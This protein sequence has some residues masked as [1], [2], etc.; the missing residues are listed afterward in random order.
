MGSEGRVSLQTQL[1]SVSVVLVS[2]NSFAEEDRMKWGPEKAETGMQDLR[3][4][5]RLCCWTALAFGSHVNYQLLALPCSPRVSYLR[6]TLN[7]FLPCFALP[8]AALTPSQ[9][10][11]A[12]CLCTELGSESPLNAW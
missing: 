11:E 1:Q 9:L 7:H 5:K 3:H 6:P 4:L 2:S 12:H 8:S 10:P